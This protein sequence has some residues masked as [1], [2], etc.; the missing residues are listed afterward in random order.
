MSR[1][2]VS[3]LVALISIILSACDGPDL[4]V[5]TKKP[6]TFLQLEKVLPKNKKNNDFINNSDKSLDF[7]IG[8][9]ENIRHISSDF[10][11]SV[12]K[13]VEADPSI[14][15]ANQDYRANVSA[16]AISE[17]QKD[18]QITGTVYSGVE[19]V[20]DRTAGVAL[21]LTAR[22]MV[23]DGGVIEN[24]TLGQKFL[25]ES[26]RY[27]LRAKMDERAK[28]LSKIW[29]DLDLY[30]QLN[31]ML[32]ER[33]GVLDPLIKQLERIAEAGL[34]DAS[35]VAAA[36]RTV[37]MIR[38]K[39]TEVSEKLDQTK[40]D[41]LNAFGDLPGYTSFDEALIN[42]L[43]PKN[44]T[45]QMIIDSPGMLSS[46]NSYM[47][48]EADVASTKAKDNYNVGFE[49]RVT[50]PFGGSDRSSD[51]SVGLVVTRTLYDGN[52]LDSEIKQ[53]EA[54]AAS[55]LASLRSFHKEALRSFENT[56][57]TIVSMDEA[58]ALSKQS[59]SAAKDEISYLRKQLV[60]GGSTLD[61]VLSV[62]ARLFEAESKE[63]TYQAEQL[64]AKL[65]I[66]STL[67]LL[68]PAVGLYDR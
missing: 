58:I 13:A 37:S 32:S 14:I 5:L 49:T 36:Q 11:E 29:I 1:F 43:V 16:L 67:G 51:E 22:R 34:G 42:S 17:S 26:S 15:S 47:A 3:L 2:S 24:K 25:A 52:K 62:E 27:A 60:I 38:V 64:K 28:D 21:A 48:A 40:V 10:S 35:Q 55:R 33:L 68:G 18:F 61:E 45:N 20:T 53:G 9:N 65:S 50:R 39:Q 54:Q 46:Y 57:Q 12:R 7:I 19:D 23:F 44:L 66:A 41:F 31:A 8:S 6:L 63:I 59:V 4:Q 30:F 56:K